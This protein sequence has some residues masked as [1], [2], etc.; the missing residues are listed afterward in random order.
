MF[1]LS[2]LF[3][4]FKAISVLSL[5]PEGKVFLLMKLI[6]CRIIQPINLNRKQP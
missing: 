6:G 1:V 2:L 3:L 4:L 5:A